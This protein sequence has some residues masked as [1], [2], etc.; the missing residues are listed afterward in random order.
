MRL[1]II[2]ILIL[3]FSTNI[4]ADEYFLS[5]GLGVINSADYYPAQTK[6]ANI[7]YRSYFLPGF[8]WNYK[9]GFWVDNSPVSNRSG[10]IYGSVG[11]GMKVQI[12]YVEAR[13]GWG[14]AAI[15]SPD[16]Y[17]G[18]RFPQF[19]GEVYLGLRDVVGH[20][21]GIQY[22]HISSSGIV[23]PNNGRDFLLLQ[24]SMKL[25]ILGD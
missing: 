21:I 20:G 14:L 10:S 8:Y 22:E 7:G 25:P 12:E 23:M 16:S 17:L 4:L 1:F 11:L 2:S 5:Y 19:N 3:V 15:S 24:L 6:V 9:A 18:G 13:A